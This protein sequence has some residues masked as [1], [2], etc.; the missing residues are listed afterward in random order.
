M[1]TVG[2]FHNTRPFVRFEGEC[3]LIE[4]RGHL[5]FLEPAQVPAPRTEGSIRECG[6]HIREWRAVREH[7][8]GLLGAFLGFG[9]AALRPGSLYVSPLNQDVREVDFHD[10]KPLNDVKPKRR[11]DHSGARPNI[12]GNHRGFEVSVH[13]PR[14]EDA[15]RASPRSGTIIGL[16]LRQG[17]KVGAS[18]Q[19]AE[20]LGSDAFGLVPVPRDRI[21]RT[22]RIG[23]RHQN[24]ADI[25]A[26]VGDFNDALGLAT[27]VEL[28][29]G[30]RF[31]RR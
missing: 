6:S 30:C 23:V 10:G 15:Q 19:L 25:E 4:L 12:Q 18:G 31:E 21:V 24:V 14:R 5:A 26:R 17:L 11:L 20:Y 2:G 9:A 16:R 29:I 7:G 1:E 22:D 13:D 8:E 28:F 27:L 3:D